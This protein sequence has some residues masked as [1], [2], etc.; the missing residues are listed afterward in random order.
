MG[1]VRGT[2]IRF[3]RTGVVSLRSLAFLGR[4]NPG[5][6]VGEMKG[7]GRADL[8]VCHRRRYLRGR[9]TLPTLTGMRM[10]DAFD[11]ASEA[12]RHVK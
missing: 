3:R 11:L 12:A 6:E 2:I 9:S 8:V 4:E 1:R 5:G 10:V 7:D